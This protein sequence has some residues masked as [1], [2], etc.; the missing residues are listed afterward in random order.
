MRIGIFYNILITA[1][2][3]TFFTKA[4]A[5][6]TLSIDNVQVSNSVSCNGSCDGELTVTYSG[7]VGNVSFQWFDANNS[8]LGIN[9][10][11][12]PNLCA[13]SYSITITDANN[14]I[15][16]SN[17]TLTEK[18]AINYTS[19]RT[20][21]TCNGN[22]GEL[23]ITGT[24]G[25][26]QFLYGIDGGAL[27][28]SGTFPGLSVGFYD[29]TIRD[30]CG[31]SST[32]REYITATDG[33]NLTPNYIEP[34]CFGEDNG[35]IS[36]F[37]FG[38]PVLAYSIDGGIST[39]NNNIFSNLAPETYDILVEDGNGCQALVVINMIE[40]DSI[41]IIPELL[42]ETCVGNNGEATFHAVGG[43][44]AFDFSFD[45]SPFQTDSTFTGLVGGTYTYNIED[46]N[47]CAVNGQVTLTTGAGATINNVL[48]TN[49]TCSDTCN[50]AVLIT[51]TGN[52]PLSYDLNGT[53]Q[54]T[55]SYNELCVGNY[56]LTISDIDGCISTQNITLSAP[57]PPTAG[58][59]VSDTTGISPLNVV[60]TNS[61]TGAA[62]YNW[63]FG[64][65][66]SSTSSDANPTFTFNEIG[67]YN[68]ILIAANG[69][70][71]DSAFA[72]I[73]V[74][75][76]PGVI[77][78]NVFTPNN[79]GVN[80]IFRPIMIGIEAV[81]GSVFNRW[82]EKVYEWYGKNSYWD[83]YTQPSGQLAPTGP[84]YYIINATDINGVTYENQGFV[85]L[86]R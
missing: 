37:A 72:T 48:S 41:Y 84:Y 56:T 78:P 74:S 69:A 71:Y 19:T 55:G 3:V 83:G 45:S 4:D 26:N 82:G 17:F 16:S 64:D 33:P 11:I 10:A 15:V 62:D 65:S 40:P 81:E 44:G 70:C 6:C 24:G 35:S 27:Q 32:F 14:C 49:P 47:N 5:Q 18:P 1:I 85:Y 36:L 79:D 57:S 59:T 73:T 25:C 66:L 38:A 22:T 68:V 54:S 53:I 75:G 77:M 20:H 31:C 9:N 86:K 50:G 76:E 43:T 30:T 2:F 67:A 61:S 13:G 28:A 23:T 7:E 58:F 39:T 52:E 60:F 51:A 42:N 29:I 12:A 8:D 46:A 80:D 21:T 63:I 34:A